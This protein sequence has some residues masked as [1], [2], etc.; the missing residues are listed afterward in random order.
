MLYNLCQNISNESDNFPGTAAAD[1]I[2]P[3][4]PKL[5]TDAVNVLNMTYFTI[6]VLS[7]Q[8]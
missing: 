6:L 5:W 3:E 8:I 2:W 1:E 7:V 4:G